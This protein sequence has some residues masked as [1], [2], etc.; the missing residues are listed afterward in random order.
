MKEKSFS[1]NAEIY[2]S[3]DIKSYMSLE[4]AHQQYEELMQFL[5]KGNFHISYDAFLNLLSFCDKREI[6]VFVVVDNKIISTAQG[7]LALTPPR[8]HLLVNNVVTHGN[9]RKCGYGKLAISYLE[10]LVTK[11][12][13]ENSI[14]NEIEVVLTNNPNKGNGDFYKALG[15]KSRTEENKNPT[16]VWQKVLKTK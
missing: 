14:S 10:K 8:L 9:Y 12:W 4:N 6:I 15:Y 2:D 11:N 16:V 3:L 13:S 5:H 1:F 7:S